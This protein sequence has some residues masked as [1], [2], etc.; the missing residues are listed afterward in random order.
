LQEYVDQTVRQQI[1]EVYRSYGEKDPL[2]FVEDPIAST[3]II[4]HEDVGSPGI[5]K[6]SDLIDVDALVERKKREEKQEA[7]R[8]MRTHIRGGCGFEN[9]GGQVG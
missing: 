7:I 8:K 2:G 4:G 5:T 6:V 3:G 1:S 9:R